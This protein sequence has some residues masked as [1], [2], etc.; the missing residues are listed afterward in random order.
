MTL[1]AGNVPIGLPPQRIVTDGCMIVGDAAHQAEPI[2]GGGIANAMLAGRYAA[3]VAA[4][5]IEVGDVSAEALEA[6]PRRWEATRGRQ[7]ARNHRLRERFPGPAR[8][9]EAFVRVFAMAASGK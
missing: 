5:A 1:I 6:Y 3:E 9:S 8:V 7:V 4:Q 2:T